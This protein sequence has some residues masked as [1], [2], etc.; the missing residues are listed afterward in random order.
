MIKMY[1]STQFFPYFEEA[2]R[3]ASSELFL[4]IISIYGFIAR[5]T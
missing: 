5:Y 1:L 2:V 4:C 3:D